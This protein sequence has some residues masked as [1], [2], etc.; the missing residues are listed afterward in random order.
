MIIDTLS[1]RLLMSTH[2]IITATEVGRSLS[3]ILNKIHY[4]GESYEIRRGKEIIAQMIPIAGK[5]TGLK[6]SE[7][8]ALFKR[9]PQ[10]DREDQE[11]FEK[12]IEQ[13]RFEMKSEHNP[14]D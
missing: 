2:H 6:I 11:M 5:K 3:T 7:L 14:W 13:I 8:N 9:L 10:L 1:E 12:D 4:Q